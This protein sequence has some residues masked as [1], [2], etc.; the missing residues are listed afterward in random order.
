[1]FP[2]FVFTNLVCFIFTLF[3]LETRSEVFVLILV[4]TPC[5]AGA[6]HGNYYLGH[7]WQSVKKALKRMS[8]KFKLA[9]IDSIVSIFNP[10]NM[11]EKIGAIVLE[12]EMWIVKGYDS[13]PSWDS[14][15]RGN[16]HKL[17]I[18]SRDLEIGFKRVLSMDFDKIFLLVNVRGYKLASIYAITRINNN[19]PD[20]IYIIDIPCT[21]GWFEHGTH[22]LSRLIRRNINRAGFYTTR[23]ALNF[24]EKREFNI[25]IPN[26]YK[27]W[28]K[29][30]YKPVFVR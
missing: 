5:N 11:R 7:N 19:V 14:F 2:L 23:Q 10:H 30:F 13:K 12:D 1:V 8:I 28:E 4:I 27:Y 3:L 15:K 21:V 6:K 9:A 26:E 20:N 17:R 24:L 25:T 22:I 18:V 29:D 16:F